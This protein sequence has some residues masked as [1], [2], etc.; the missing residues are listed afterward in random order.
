[1]NIFSFSK[2][3]HPLL[4]GGSRITTWKGLPVT[5]GIGESWEVCGLDK[6]SSVI[7]NGEFAGQRLR[8]VIA[9]HPVEILGKAV[10]EKYNNQLPLLA[11][12]I[13]A[14][15]DLSIQVHPNDEMAMREHNS[16]GKTEMW[17][18]IDATPGAYL[19]SGFKK[20]ITPEEY[21]RR[22]AD[23]TIIDVLAKHEV[24][25]GDVF[26][27]PAGRVHAI[28]S[29]VFLAEIQ[30]NSDV[31]YRI[32]DYKR[33]DKDG[34][35]RQLHTELA[36][37]ALDFEVQD[38]YRTGYSKDIQRANPCIDSPFFSVRVVEADKPIHRNLLKYDSFIISMCLKGRCQIRSKKDGSFIEL[39]E[40]YSCLIPAVNAD[41][42]VVP[43]D[44]SVRILDAFIDNKDRNLFRKI[45]RFFHLS[46]K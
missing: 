40:G 19:Y 34:K 29:G 1:M 46:S 9:Q 45:T 20:H 15:Q 22:V 36:A 35:E 25:T 6:A 2:N 23:G 18:V 43:L 14:K 3:L 30:Q 37:Q 41:Y 27:I 28:C 21:K 31:T 7:E 39:K 12:F 44:G 5:D 8:D 42:D 26:Y 17:Y 10:A 38:E 11:K 16:F 33:K 4:W 13:D 24:H 32:Y